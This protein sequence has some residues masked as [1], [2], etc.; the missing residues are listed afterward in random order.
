MKRYILVDELDLNWILKCINRGKIKTKQ[1]V[2][3]VWGMCVC[4]VL[5]PTSPPPCIYSR[6]PWGETCRT[7]LED[8]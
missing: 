2:S 8:L 6:E 7:N 5:Y 3:E 4:P 1:E